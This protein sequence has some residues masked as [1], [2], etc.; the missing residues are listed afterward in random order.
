[1]SRDPRRTHVLCDATL[2]RYVGNSRARLLLELRGGLKVFGVC[3][4]GGE[5]AKV[6]SA[7]HGEVMLPL[8]DACFRRPF[9]LFLA[10][11]V[12][13]PERRPASLSLSV[14]RGVVG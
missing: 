11:R 13:S 9:P 5:K 10:V 1:M 7:V 4:G 6:I 3:W 2:G 14:K 12:G 8:R